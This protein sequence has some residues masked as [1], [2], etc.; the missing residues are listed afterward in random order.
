M[1]EKNNCSSMVIEE[2]F[3][4]FNAKNGSSISDKHLSAQLM[5]KHKTIYFTVI[6][7]FPL[8]LSNNGS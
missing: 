3:P 8:R 1:G 7:L 4:S 6:I 5:R 2:H